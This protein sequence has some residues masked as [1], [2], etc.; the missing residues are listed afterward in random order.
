MDAQERTPPRAA[1]PS[2]VRVVKDQTTIWSRNPSSVLAVVKAGTVLRAVARE[3]RWIEVLVPAKEGGKG[4][5]GFVLA[6]H[7]EHIAGT[8]D[9][10]L[11]QPR[12]VRVH[13]GCVG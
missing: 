3:D 12:R 13:V 5:T 9:I 1:A 8:P 2:E 10:P 11:R 7:V 6:A 4:N